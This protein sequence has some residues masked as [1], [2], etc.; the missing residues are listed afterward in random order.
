MTPNFCDFNKD[1]EIGENCWKLAT[2]TQPDCYLP[3][4]LD[5]ENLENFVDDLQ[6]HK[7]FSFAERIKIIN[8]PESSQ[9]F[10]LGKCEVY[11]PQ[12]RKVSKENCSEVK[13]STYCVEKDGL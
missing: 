2:S 5:V 8:P 11:N 7:K 1:L 6:G 3:T 10:S 4:R 12:T 9:E 13:A